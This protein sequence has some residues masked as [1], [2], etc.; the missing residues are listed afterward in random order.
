MV[1]SFLYDTAFATLAGKMLT[2][3]CHRHVE[4]QNLGIPG[5][6]LNDTYS[7]A[8]EALALKPDILLLGISPRDV[9]E[10]NTFDPDASPASHAQSE[11]N[12]SKKNV[13]SW[14]RILNPIKSSRAFMML[15]HFMYQNPATTANIQLLHGDGSDYVRPPFSP[16]WRQRLSNF[17]TMLRAMSDKARAA[18][19]PDGPFGGSVSDSS[20]VSQYSPEIRS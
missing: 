3:E 9:Q 6:L 11:D 4:F 16:S 14:I 18:S 19:T 7:R 20:S 5:Y 15:Q 12:K 8:G 1:I 10:L 2:D 17:D 13:A